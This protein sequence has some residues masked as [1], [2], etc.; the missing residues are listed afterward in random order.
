MFNSLYRKPCDY[1]M[2]YG[3]GVFARPRYIRKFWRRQIRLRE[4]IGI[5]SDKTTPYFHYR[6]CNFLADKFLTFSKSTFVDVSNSTDFKKSRNSLTVS[7]R[8]TVHNTENVRP[9][10]HFQ[11]MYEGG[12]SPRSTHAF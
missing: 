4:E 1:H 9:Y 2:V 11:M 5:R 3:Y 7:E 8:Q 10:P 12:L 6:K